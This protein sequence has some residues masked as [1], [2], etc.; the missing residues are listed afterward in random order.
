M[1]KRAKSRFSKLS[2][3]LATVEDV[4]SCAFRAPIYLPMNMCI[5]EMLLM[6]SSAII[7]MFLRTPKVEEPLEL[8]LTSWPGFAVRPSGRKESRTALSLS[9]SLLCKQ[10][11]N[12]LSS[13][14]LL[15]FPP[16]RLA[17]GPPRGKAELCSCGCRPSFAACG[18]TES[19]QGCAECKESASFVFAGIRY[20][21]GNWR[22]LRVS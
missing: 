19:Q 2:F 4:L 3:A 11:I 17:R 21:K 20:H 5:G 12:L 9:I 10:T 7:I 6:Y 18:Q 1:Q 16:L 13:P 15:P 8:L 14:P 22:R